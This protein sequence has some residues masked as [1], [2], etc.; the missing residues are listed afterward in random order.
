[1]AKS[2]FVSLV[3]NLKFLGFIII[4]LMVGATGI[5]GVARK[6]NAESKNTQEISLRTTN[7]TTALQVVKVEKV[8]D[9]GTKA[10]VTLLNQSSKK[11]TAFVLSVGNLSITKDLA[12]T[13][14]SLA[15]GET[16]V[17][18]IPFY[19]F[20]AAASKNPDKAGDLEIS[21]V[22]FVDDGEGETR[23]VQSIRQ[24]HQGLK[25]QAERILSLLRGLSN[26]PQKSSE[27]LVRQ[28]DAQAQNLKATPENNN[29]SSNYT[30]GRNWVNKLFDDDVN[31]IKQKQKR[32]SNLNSQDELNEL[33]LFYEKFLSQF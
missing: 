17:E 16:I 2:R 23:H 20:E 1:M 28:F 8:E 13:G 26:S 22:Y 10:K 32:D 21:A 6:R 30:G 29:S 12:Y 3:P 5:W 25:E 15:S 27:Y 31:K 7:K 4:S 11:I 14:D 33:I 24:T 9:R 18:M 19:N